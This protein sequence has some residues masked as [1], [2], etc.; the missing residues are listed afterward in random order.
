VFDTVA[1]QT[2]IAGS[3]A[4]AAKAV[5]GK[6]SPKAVSICK[7]SVDDFSIFDA[8]YPAISPSTL[9]LLPGSLSDV[10]VSM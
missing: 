4:F 6:P 1:G 8:N 3:G 7:R 10:Q 2:L 9:K 5:A